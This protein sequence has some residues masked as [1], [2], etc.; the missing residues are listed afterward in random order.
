MAYMYTIMGKEAMG[1][2]S[3]LL[4]NLLLKAVIVGFQFF[5]CKTL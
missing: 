4:Q 3:P 2:L 5:L 1:W